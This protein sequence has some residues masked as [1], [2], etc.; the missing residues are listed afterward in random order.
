M[1]FCHYFDTC[2]Y[3]LRKMLGTR[4][5]SVG[6][7]PDF[8]DSRDPMMIFS[9]YRDPIFFDSGDPMM[10]FSDYRDPIFFDS[11][12]PMMIFSDCRDPIFNSRTRIV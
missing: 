3:F 1:A 4:C 7:R 9:D 6:T 10:I 11:G 8:S 5:E 12:D 2:R